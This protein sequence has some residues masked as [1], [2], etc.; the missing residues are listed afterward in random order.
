LKKEQKMKK[1]S[2][3]Q[4]FLQKGKDILKEKM[5]TMTR[6]EAI[7]SMYIVAGKTKKKR[8]AATKEEE[9][10]K[11]KGL[12]GKFLKAC[13]RK[14]T[15][16]KALKG[17]GEKKG[18]KEKKEQKEKKEKKE[19]KKKKNNLKTKPSAK[20][21]PSLKTKP[22]VL[23][24]TITKEIMREELKARKKQMKKTLAGNNGGNFKQLKH[25]LKKTLRWNESQ[26]EIM[27]KLKNLETHSKS[28]EVGA[29]QGLQPY[30]ALKGLI[31][32]PRDLIRPYKAL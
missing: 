32:G 30:K 2:N 12:K 10:K 28:D 22:S 1:W 8:S 7:Q 24:K 4:V 31:K 9:Q 6:A 14:L 17:F 29:L 16:M 25:E 3:S 20:S 27:N 18:K 11:Q 23:K 5:K 21:K 15:D 19:K 13:T 26:Y